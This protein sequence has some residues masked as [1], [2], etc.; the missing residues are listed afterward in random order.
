MAQVRALADR[1]EGVVRL[2]AAEE[3]LRMRIESA[4]AESARLAEHVAE[5]G[6]RR[7]DA[8]DALEDAAEVLAEADDD[9]VWVERKPAA[10]V[11]HVRL[12]EDEVRKRR[13]LDHAMAFFRPVGGVHVTEGKD[14]LELA[15]LDVT[16][17]SYLEAARNEYGADA[18]LFIGDDVTDE[19]DLRTLSHGDLG[20]K[21]GSADDGP[22]AATA[23]LPDTAAVTA[24]LREFAEARAAATA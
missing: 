18:V 13:V 19:T 11:L 4:E 6:Q 22:S 24:F 10:R 12:L 21:V 7:D 20:I 8:A 14:I 9:R 5:A 16:K 23:F 17:G 1:R 3:S 2:V 15:V